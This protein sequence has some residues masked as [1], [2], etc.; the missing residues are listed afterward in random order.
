V[1]Q[2]LPLVDTVFIL[3]LLVLRLET[4]L[5]SLLLEAEQ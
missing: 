3:L 1:E 2:L 4:L 5:L